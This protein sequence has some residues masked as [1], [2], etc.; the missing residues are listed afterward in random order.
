MSL[1]IPFHFGWLLNKK[2]ARVEVNISLAFLH[3]IGIALHPSPF[4]SDIAIFVSMSLGMDSQNRSS[5]V[6]LMHIKILKLSDYKLQLC[7]HE[8]KYDMHVCTFIKCHSADGYF[9]DKRLKVF[10]TANKVH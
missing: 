6:D 8:S 10:V 4:V 3:W 2:A 9:V 5:C 1:S 7:T